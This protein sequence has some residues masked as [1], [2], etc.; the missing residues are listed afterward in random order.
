MSV[1]DVYC[2]LETGASLTL[3]PEQVLL[4]PGR[5]VG[6]I[7]KRNISLWKGVSSLLSY[8]AKLKA[9]NPNR[10]KDLKRI[11]FSGEPLPAKYLAEWMSAYPGKEFYNAY[12]PTECTGISTSYRV[13]SILQDLG[14]PIPIGKACANTEIFL[15]C[16]DERL[17]RVGEVG[18]LCIRGSSL[19]CGYWND[20][21]RTD[22]VFVQNPLNKRNQER[23]YRT[24]DLVKQLPDGNYVF[25][26]R[27]DT[28]IKYMGYRIELGEIE[29]ALQ[30]LDGVKDA[31][32]LAPRGETAENPE[33]VAFLEADG[34][35]IL[36]QICEALRGKIPKYMIPTKFQVLKNLP[37]TKNGKVDRQL[38]INLSVD[39]Q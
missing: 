39:L 27:K 26:G 9:I 28:Q 37:R 13:T 17:A 35:T 5:L 4:F 23:V 12:G 16:E 30:T 2:A 8:L 19:S 10:M 3:V 7:E 14:A 11:I 6:I 24:G 32:V 1:F 36:E 18:E 29:C 34:E 15:I 21:E 22:K 20:P 38:L 25:I 33:I 31:A